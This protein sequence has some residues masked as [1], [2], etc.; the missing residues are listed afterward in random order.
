MAYNPNIPQPGDFVSSSQADILENFSQL[1]TQYGNDHVAWDAGSNNGKHKKVTLIAGTDPTTAAGEVAVYSK[2]VTGSTNLY[3]RLASNGTVIQLT[4]SS[5]VSAADPGYTLLP[6]NILMQWA[7]VTNANNDVI[8]FPKA[9]SAAPW[10][11]QCNSFPVAA[12]DA[13]FFQVLVKT[14]TN[15]TLGLRSVVNSPVATPHK[16]MYLAI[17]PA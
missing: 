10:S 15:W 16:F 11:I 2:T 7:T 13:D 1:N 6:G 8:V 5:S 3:C 14:A 12:T 4:N 9:F 17:G